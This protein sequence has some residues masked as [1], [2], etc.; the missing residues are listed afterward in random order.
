M[1]V[2]GFTELIMTK[3]LLIPIHLILC[4]AAICTSS[5]AAQVKS[6]ADAPKTLIQDLYKVHNQGK[7]SIFSGKSKAPL[8]RFFDKKLADLLWKILT[9]KSDEV[10]P[11]DFDPLF[12]AQDL[13]LR[14]F[15]IGAS[16][17][18]EQKSMVTVTFRNDSRAE[19][20]KFRLRHTDAG[21]KVENIVYA[22]GS[23]LIKILSSS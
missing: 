17:G 2:L 22:D 7:G 16:T 23:D 10:G 19:T 6:P 13:L 1:L 15:R 21:W 14:N 5:I 8:Q 11:L 4:F 20:I 18:D 3:K 12:N 9:A